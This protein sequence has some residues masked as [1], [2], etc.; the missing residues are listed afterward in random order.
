VGKIPTKLKA[1]LLTRSQD[2]YLV[3]ELPKEI[4]LLL[5]SLSLSIPFQKSWHSAR[6]TQV[7]DHLVPNR[8]LRL[9]EFQGER[10][11]GSFLFSKAC[12][13]LYRRRFKETEDAPL[14]AYFP[15]RKLSSCYPMPLDEAV[16]YLI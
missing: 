6:S 10:E 9:F 8:I 4:P 2:V 14:A 5:L 3:F 11:R 7:V 13:S 12:K 15:L 16:E 1:A